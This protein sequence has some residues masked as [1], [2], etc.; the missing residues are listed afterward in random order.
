MIKV[1]TILLVEDNDADARLLMEMA[2]EIHDLSLAI[3]HVKRLAEALSL[4]D[5]KSF[6]AILL[7]L[8]LPDSFGSETLSNLNPV[9]RE[10]PVIILTGFND[11]DLAVTA[12]K[13]GA[14]DYLIKGEISPDILYRSLNYA[15]ERKKI[16]GELARAKSEIE[17][18]AR[19]LAELNEDKDKFFSIV[20]HDLR[21]PFTSLLAYAEYLSQNLE[22]LSDEEI[23]TFSGN[24]H[25]SLK[26]TLSLLENLLD[27]SMLQSGKLEYAPESFNLAPLILELVEL[28]R[29]SAE[30]KG[31][32]IIYEGPEELPVYADKN[33]INTVIRN[34]LSNAVKYSGED[35]KIT[36]SGKLNFNITVVSVCDMGTGMEQEEIDR[37]FRIDRNLSKPGTL[38]EKGTGLGLILSRDFVEKNGGEIRAFSSPGK[39]SRF[40][41]T[42]PVTQPQEQ[43]A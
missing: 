18:N 21:S 9:S 41:F 43:Q 11:R 22:E 8:G 37:L 16:V 17:N 23:R 33:M 34:L 2:S 3:T 26:K 7:D 13:S 12:I 42:L 1:T 30:A 25:K 28:Y 35:T 6:D 4:L 36:V 32:V 24:I 10:A 27:W 15:M 20:A 5:E 39:G 31:I 29:I 19:K 14:Q 40:V 38:N